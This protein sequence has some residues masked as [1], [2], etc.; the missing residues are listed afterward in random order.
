MILKSIY[1]SS[2]EEG[3]M[4][5]NSVIVLMEAV[6]I[7]LDNEEKPIEDW[8]SVYKFVGDISITGK[9]S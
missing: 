8:A 5:P 1:W 9:E 7:A 3:S 6:D 4:L 2:Y